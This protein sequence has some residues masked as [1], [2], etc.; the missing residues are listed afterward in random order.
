MLRVRTLL[1]ALTVPLALTG[2]GGAGAQPSPDRAI[3]CT[4]WHRQAVQ[5]EATDRLL[6]AR[7]AY[8]RCRDAPCEGAQ[9]RACG[10]ALRRLRT[11]VPRLLVKAH[12]PDG[13]ELNQARV[14]VD[15]AFEAL[16]TS[17][18]VDPGA[19]LV[20][21]EHDRHVG[22]LQRVRLAP[23]EHRVLS[24]E[25]RPRRAPSEE[26]L[27][28]LG[29]RLETL[30]D[31]SWPMPEAA[32]TMAGVGVA[33]LAT[34]IV[35]DAY[36]ADGLEGMRGCA[37]ECEAAIVDAVE[38][39]IQFSRIALGMSMVSLAT[40]AWLALA[41]SPADAFAPRSSGAPKLRMFAGPGGLRVTLTTRFDESQLL[42]RG[43]PFGRPP[44]PLPP[45]PIPEEIFC[46]W[47]CLEGRPPF[48]LRGFER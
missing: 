20:R 43:D 1:S 3:A 24:V 17:F 38:R 44:Q 33:S 11:Q 9:R 19:H 34:A 42:R 26:R 7:D 45:P 18:E 29:D 35:L 21:V 23:G 28:I 40:A 32:W 37:P 36:A 46:P 41:E 16:G 12:D 39:D 25:L 27:Q 22:R 30:R 10:A 15:G 6:A 48:D 8:R 5:L 14:F 47:G 13:N 2:S 31:Q 4:R